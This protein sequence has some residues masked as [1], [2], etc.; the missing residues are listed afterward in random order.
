MS[1]SA[2]ASNPEA[3][4]FSAHDLPILLSYTTLE[5]EVLALLL[6]RTFVRRETRRFWI[7]GRSADRRG[8]PFDQ[9]SS[10]RRR[11]IAG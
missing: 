8:L 5:A 11:S 6:G 1:I 9:A 7:G 3:P 2:P 4:S 10:T